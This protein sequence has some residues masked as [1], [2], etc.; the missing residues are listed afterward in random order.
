MSRQKGRNFLREC[1]VSCP[2]LLIPFSSRTFNRALAGRQVTGPWCPPCP[3]YGW[4]S[5]P[6]PKPRYPAAPQLVHLT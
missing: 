2:Y 6:H 4:R 1:T 3:L 5:P